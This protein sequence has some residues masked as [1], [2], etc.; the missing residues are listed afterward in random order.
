MT[1]SL[2]HVQLNASAASMSFYRTLLRHLG[3]TLMDDDG[4][5]FGATN[6]TTDLWI[7]ETDPRFASRVFHR[8]ATGLNHIAFR[9][10]SRADVDRFADDFLAAHAIA[11]LYGG[12]R[13]YPE[14]RAGYY[15]VF[16]ESPD[17]L[18]LEVAHIPP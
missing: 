17:R 16:F 12:P 14:Y 8:K 1:A 18:K 13:D 5:T 7:T 11:A 2:Y 6:G 3:Y 9:V 4:T 15:A 10:S